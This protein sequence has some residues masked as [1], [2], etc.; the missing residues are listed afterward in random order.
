[1]TVAELKKKLNEFDDDELVYVWHSNWPSENYSTNI[2]VSKNVYYSVS[3]SCGNSIV[4]PLIL[5]A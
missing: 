1:M 4:K 3:D 5:F 2:T